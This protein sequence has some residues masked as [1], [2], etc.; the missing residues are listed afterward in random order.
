MKTATAEIPV[1][2]EIGEDVE[3]VHATRTGH[4]RELGDERFETSHLRRRHR[5]VR[6]RNH[7]RHLD[8]ELNHVDDEH[9]PE[10]G[11]CREHDVEDTHPHERL[12]A[13]QPEQDAGDLDGRQVD[14][15]HDHAV[16]QQ[17]QINRAEAAQ[18]PRRT[19]RV[20]NLVELEIG[21]DSR[22]PPEARVEKHRRD[23][24]QH[25]RP[26]HPV[27]RHAVAAHDV[28]DQV[29]RVA[30]ER[31]GDHRQP[32][33]PPRDRPPRDEEFGGALARAL[34]VEQGRDEAD[35]ERREDDDP[36]DQLQLH[37][38]SWDWRRPSL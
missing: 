21:H 25:E 5:E 31:R 9:A 10:P 38:V 28:G 4:V 32:C 16:E 7:R 2:R 29:R 23:A 3:V 15:R 11:V 20:S 19:P 13:L 14:G 24:R 36:V 35:G 18:P 8:E 30:A 33:Q 17:A 22:A 34:S 26:P 12:P 27:A 37:R 1:A 6:G